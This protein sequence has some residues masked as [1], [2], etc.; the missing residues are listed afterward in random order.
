MYAQNKY[1]NITAKLQKR[2]SWS[3]TASRDKTKLAWSICIYLYIQYQIIDLY[4]YF[5]IK[6][7]T[8]G[9]IYNNTVQITMLKF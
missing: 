6:Q 2:G 5:R 8:K 1:Y 3:T 7:K 4:I 9:Q